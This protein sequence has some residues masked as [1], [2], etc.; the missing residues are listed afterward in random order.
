VKQLAKVM[1]VLALVAAPVAGRAEIQKSGKQVFP[2][3]L[4]VGF[5]PLGF[6]VGFVSG[7]GG[8]GYKLAADFA[9]QLKDWGANGL[10]L[11]LGGGLNYGTNFTGN[12][13]GCFH[14]IEIWA[15]VRLHLNRLNIPLVPWVQAGIA[16]LV[17]IYGGAFGGGISGTG[18]GAGLRFGGGLHYWIIKNLGLGV[19]SHFNL[20]GVGYPGGVAG[21][22]GYWDFLLGMRAAF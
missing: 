14:Q 2:G 19:E 9:G 21:F 17:G 3:K 22:F 4:M 15:F 20:G 12:C 11:Y 1:L 13:V 18:G 10:Q 8:F 5:H 16:G 6:Q 7:A